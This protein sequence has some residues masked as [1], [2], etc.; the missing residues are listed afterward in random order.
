MCVG[1]ACA[2]DGDLVVLDGRL[3]LSH[4]C[5]G[6]AVVDASEKNSQEPSVAA[7]ALSWSGKWWRG[8]IDE[9]VLDEEPAWEEEDVTVREEDS[10]DEGEDSEGADLDGNTDDDEEEDDGLIDCFRSHRVV[11]EADDDDDDDVDAMQDDA[12]MASPGSAAGHASSEMDVDVCEATSVDARVGCAASNGTASTTASHPHRRKAESKPHSTVPT[13]HSSTS[14]DDVADRDTAEEE[15][16][17]SRVIHFLTT[18]KEP[19]TLRAI[20]TA[21]ERGMHT[22]VDLDQLLDILR[23]YPGTFVVNADDNPAK[24]EVWLKGAELREA[25]SDDDVSDDDWSQE[26]L[27]LDS[28]TDGDDNAES[29]LLDPAGVLAHAVVGLNDRYAQQRIGDRQC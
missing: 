15:K 25:E 9:D 19:T 10:N 26:D 1:R 17:V 29:A 28:D 23:S 21:V 3:F 8:R 22:T 12:I 11:I 2:T 27:G 5:N 18:R 20:H 7:A 4:L 13:G 14:Q 16:V 6:Y 24:P